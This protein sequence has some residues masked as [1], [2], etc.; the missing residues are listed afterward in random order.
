MA[1]S[2]ADATAGYESDP[3]AKGCNEMVVRCVESLTLGKNTNF[4]YFFEIG[5]GTGG[6]TSFVLPHLNP[7]ASKYTFSDLS[8]AFLMNA[9]DRFGEKYPFVEYAIYNGDLDPLEQGYAPN[10][11][12]INI[13]TNVIHATSHL[14]VTMGGIH[15]ILK[16]GGS[17]I[18][19]EVQTPALLS[20]DMTYGLTDG[21]WMFVDYEHRENFPLMRTPQWQKLF[22]ECG[23][24]N[25]YNTPYLG[26]FVAQQI[27]CARIPMLADEDL[28]DKVGDI[29]RDPLVNTPGVFLLTGGVGGLGL[30]T[31]LILLRQGAM[32]MTFVSRRDRVPAESAHHFAIISESNATIQRERA[33]ASHEGSMKKLVDQAK[34]PALLGVLAGAGVLSDGMIKNQTRNSY[35]VVFQPKLMGAWY[36]HKMTEN[37]KDELCMFLSLSSA[38]ALGSPGQSNHSSANMG[39]DTFTYF[40]WSLG[41]SAS[42]INWGAVAEVGYAARHSTMQKQ[43]MTP[44]DFAWGA[45]HNSSM[46]NFIHIM[47][48]GVDLSGGQGKVMSHYVSRRRVMHVIMNQSAKKGWS[49]EAK[50]ATWRAQQEED[51]RRALFGAVNP[52]DGRWFDGK[53]TIVIEGPLVKWPKG[54]TTNLK[55]KSSETALLMMQDGQWNKGHK[56]DGIIKWFNGEVWVP[57]ARRE[58]AATTE[59]CP[60]PLDFNEEDMYDMDESTVFDALQQLQDQDGKGGEN[61]FLGEVL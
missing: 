14:T 60:M 46:F 29:T 42:S 27:I 25:Q 48:V 51:A 58:E 53:Q 41:L 33:S 23:Y 19:N 59:P 1:L 36:L 34:N 16:I 39:L 24:V 38:A 10:Q 8:Q 32:Y 15:R 3:T 5:S 28:T 22:E 61:I 37:K 30:L 21:W 55:L 47:M 56:M 6:T 26:A 2:F 45:L 50:E 44:F 18:F 12:D 11:A 7:W 43:F 4:K 52:F 40:R 57:E 31:A 17:I 9:H 54:Q 20:E 35:A 13:A 49:R